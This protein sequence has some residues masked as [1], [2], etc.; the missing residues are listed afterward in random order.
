MHIILRLKEKPDLCLEVEGLLPGLDEI[1]NFPIRYGNR[2]VSLS[3][4]FDFEVERSDI[5]RITFEGDM[6]RVKRIGWGLESGEI[7]VKGN[8]G[9]YLGAF[10]KGGKIIVEGDVGS[11]SG[12]NMEGGEIHIQGN[13]KDYLCASYRG[14]WRGMRGGTVY[15]E[16]NV[17]KE[18]GSYMVGGKIFVE[19]YA[20]DFI[21]S[22]MKGGLIYVRGA[23]ARVG[24]GMTGGSIVL[25]CV[26]E[27]LPGF[28]EEGEV[29]DL[30][31]EGEK[32]I[33]KFKVYSGDHA[34]RK[35]RG[36]L[37]VRI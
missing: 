15:V 5:Q 31:I 23:K 20:D 28:F 32:F 6:E 9:M 19:G 4:F 11:F 10:M 18:L 3:E 34:E 7:V 36:R 12:L 21:G 16:G 24:A 33:G 8:A 35:V 25:D 1:E 17:G 26:D 2:V 30:E 22:C 37:Y 13:A 14:D 29:E 27:V